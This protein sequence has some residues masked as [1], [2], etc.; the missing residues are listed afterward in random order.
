MSERREKRLWAARDASGMVYLY[1]QQPY[2]NKYGLWVIP[3]GTES[4]IYCCGMDMPLFDC[5]KKED[6]LP[7]VLTIERMG[8]NG[9]N[10]KITL[11]KYEEKLP[12]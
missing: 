3:V 10:V 8:Q 11:S 7:Y 9:Q 5:I 2:K 12:F 1:S 6:D 4:E